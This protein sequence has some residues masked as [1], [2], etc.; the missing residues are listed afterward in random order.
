M[1]LALTLLVMCML[2]LM[3]LVAKLAAIMLMFEV[4]ISMQV[5]CDGVSLAV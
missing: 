4:V 5:I 1:T 2:L 3:M